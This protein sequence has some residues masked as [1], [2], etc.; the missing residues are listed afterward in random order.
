MYTQLPLF[1]LSRF[2]YPCIRATLSPSLSL[3]LSRFAFSLS[4]A[5]FL[6][7]SL[8]CLFLH[9]FRIVHRSGTQQADSCCAHWRGTPMLS[10]LCVFSL[11][12]GLQA[13]LL[14]VPSRCVHFA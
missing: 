9:R 13:A 5:C 4:P 1:S 6:S 8:S 11:R 7:R 3:C 10:T 12:T 2:P 14:T